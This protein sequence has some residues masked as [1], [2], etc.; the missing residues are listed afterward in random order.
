MRVLYPLRYFPTLS[1]TFVYREIDALRA[2]GIEVIIASLGRRADGALQDEPPTAPVLEVPRHPIRGR[3]RPRGPGLRWLEQVQG[4]PAAARLAWLIDA[5]G[6]IDHVHAHFAGAAAEWAHALHRELG[7]GYSVTVHA[8]DLFKP[9]PTLARVLGA[10]RPA[11]VVAEHHRTHLAAMGVESRLSRCGPDLAAWALPPPPSGP[12]RALA[13]GRNVPKKGFDLLLA[14]WAALDRPGAELHIVS[15]LPGPAR[16]GVHVHGLL[17][18]A[19]VRALL[20]R[21][22][23]GVLACR[24]AADGDMD[25]VPL[26]LMEAMAAGRAVLGTAISGLPEL[27]DPKVGWLVPPEDPGA[28]REALAEAHDDPA[29][30]EARAAR[31]RGRLIERGF[32]LEA[33]AEG[34]LQAWRDAGSLRG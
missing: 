16:P 26:S 14:A 3:L 20:S 1:E 31:A 22:N 27:I 34:L 24:R 8:A 12:L 15:D 29:G 30:R 23:L 28:L 4:A 33:Q 6:P 17:P 5:M 19:A 10:A 2:R 9:R 25:G 32:T 11:L 13:V 18:P 7:L 21:C